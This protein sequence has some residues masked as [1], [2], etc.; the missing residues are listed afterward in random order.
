MALL[1]P[2]QA[3][4]LAVPSSSNVHYSKIPPLQS[5]ET[6]PVLREAKMSMQIVEQEV[7]LF[8]LERICGRHTRVCGRLHR[9]LCAE[10][11]VVIL[12]C[13]CQPFKDIAESRIAAAVALR[14]SIFLTFKPLSY[15]S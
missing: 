12:V 10:A 14:K 1:S 15:S 6:R 2:E 7:E 5:F 11:A 9:H 8:P 13:L 4:C 3:V